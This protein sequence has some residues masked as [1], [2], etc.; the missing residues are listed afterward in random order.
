M[1]MKQTVLVLTTLLFLSCSL[2]A[3]E[4]HHDTTFK[5]TV[6]I[7][8]TPVLITGQ[9][10]SFTMGYERVLG[11][12]QT[13]SA[14]I[15][16]LQL[17]TLI[18]TKDGSPV[19][20]I[21]NLRNT[22]FIGSLDYRFYFKRNRYAVPDGLYWGPFVTYYYFDNKAGVEL[23]KNDVAQGSAEVQTYLS[24]LMVGVQLGYQFVLGKRWTIDLILLGPG[25]GFYDLQMGIDADAQLEGDPEYLQGVYDALVSVFPGAEKL[26]DEQRIDAKGTSSFNGAGFRYV[27]QVGFRF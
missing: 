12:H 7:N 15:G 8:V 13:I 11:K 27:F 5:N 10:G 18:T 26:F 2:S 23:F 21:S 6:R 4:A 17:P 16:H 3:Q 19:K 20:W 24:A 25:V 1:A 9:L 22:G 14:N